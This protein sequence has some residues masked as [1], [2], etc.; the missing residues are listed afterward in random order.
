MIDIRGE[1]RARVSFR[2]TSEVF[3]ALVSPL[4]LTGQQACERSVE[5]GVRGEP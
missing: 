3:R 2:A 1:K 4:M 5:N